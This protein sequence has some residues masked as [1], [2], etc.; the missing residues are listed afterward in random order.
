MTTMPVQLVSHFKIHASQVEL[1]LSEER[2]NI[3]EF[4][5]QRYFDCESCLKS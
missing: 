3:W 5:F 4:L 2:N 1:I